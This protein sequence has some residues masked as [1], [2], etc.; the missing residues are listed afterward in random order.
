MEKKQRLSGIELLKIIAI[1]LIIVSHVIQ[2]LYTPTD[3]FGGKYVFEIKYAT[4]NIK[5]LLLVWFS[6]FGM[7]GNLIFFV[8]SAWFL[9]DSK[10]INEKKV[11]NLL[12]D[13]WIISIFILGVFLIGNWYEIPK[14]LVVKSIFP[15]IF[16]NNWYITMYILFYLIHLSLNEIILKRTKKELLIIDIMLLFF[17]FGLNYIKPGLLFITPLVEFITV[18]FVI[19]YIK[20]YLKEFLEEP[21]K[22]YI[23]LF[24]SII[25]LPVLIII[26][27]FLGLNIVFFSD[28]LQHWKGNNCIFLLFTAIILFNIF[29]KKNFIN[30]KINFIS[31]LS[32]LIYLIHE[33]ILVRT[34]L[35]P[36]IWNYIYINMGY[37]NII[38]IILIYSILVFVI[39]IIIALLYSIFI[40]KKISKIGYILYKKIKIL[41]IKKV[42]ILIF[43]S[44]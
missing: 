29:Q 42:D 12:V 36:S 19:A 13:V 24:I 34:Y 43:Y 17:Y 38:L 3:L 22:K 32:L 35:R 16:A 5:N 14:K 1:F 26:T 44:K 41:F 33:N 11:I 18:Y 37:D 6:M 31:S 7:Q 28:K 2:T 25:G 23:L 8:C 21:K 27:N 20:K 30:Q 40:Q 10:V 4:K 39:S 9:L 15:T